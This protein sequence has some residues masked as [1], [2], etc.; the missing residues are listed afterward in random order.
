MTTDEIVEAWF[1][2]DTDDRLATLDERLARWR[3]LEE[4]PAMPDVETIDPIALADRLRSFA[5]EIVEPLRCMHPAGG[6]GPGTH[7]AACCYGTGLIVTD[8]TDQAIA[9][10]ARAM[11]AAETML[12]QVPT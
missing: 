8:A 9:E 6:L 5:D 3:A 7:C 1:G 12:R 2:A 10:A 4:E 11:R